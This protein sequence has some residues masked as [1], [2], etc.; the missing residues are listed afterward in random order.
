MTPNNLDLKRLSQYNSNAR[1]FAE[2]TAAGKTDELRSLT[3]DDQYL[4]EDIQVE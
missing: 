3:E 4:P 2:A 1:N